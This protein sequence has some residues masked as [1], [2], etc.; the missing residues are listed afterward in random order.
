MV[1]HIQPRNVVFFRRLG[2]QVCGDEELYVGVPHVP[3]S[4]GLRPERADRAR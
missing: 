4:I 3:M 2:W 1:A